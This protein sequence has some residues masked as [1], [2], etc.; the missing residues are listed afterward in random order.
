ML[1]EFAEQ[2]IA[3]LLD[4]NTIRDLN[5]VVRYDDAESKD[6]LKLIHEITQSCAAAVYLIVDINIRSGEWPR[7]RGTSEEVVDA[8]LN[9]ASRPY[10]CLLLAK[11]VHQS[12]NQAFKL[13]ALSN[14]ST[15]ETPPQQRAKLIR[16][17]RVVCCAN[18]GDALR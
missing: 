12:S 7:G 11:V 3:G 10:D 8:L 15:A 17:M 6:L 9:L 13:W 16:G 1:A 14:G 5:G 4:S 2:V 18:G